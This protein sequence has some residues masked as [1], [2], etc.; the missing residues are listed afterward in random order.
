MLPI[1]KTT[2]S[3]APHTMLAYI[4]SN[5]TLPPAG[6]QRTDKFSNT[7]DNMFVNIFSYISSNII[8][9]IFSSISVTLI[10]FL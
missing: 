3:C 10:G 4:F 5:R 6:T 2:R 7:L 9:N 1:R 8:G